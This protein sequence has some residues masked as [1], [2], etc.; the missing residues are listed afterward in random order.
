MAVVEVCVSEEIA[1]QRSRETKHQAAAAISSLYGFF[2]NL[3]RPF[4]KEGASVNQH[5]V[6]NS[7]KAG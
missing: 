4:Y 3:L 2:I 6:T 5:E 1:M 7:F